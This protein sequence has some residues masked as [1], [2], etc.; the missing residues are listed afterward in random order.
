MP[1]RRRGGFGEL[2]PIERIAR[3]RQHVGQ[4]ADRRERRAADHLDGDT[5]AKLREIELDGLRRA[6]EVR[7]AENRL[8]LVA[9]HVRE[10]RAIAGPQQL[11]RA[12]AERLGSLPHGEH[13]AR[14]V[15]QRRRLPRLRLDVDRRVAVDGIHDRRQIEALRIGAREAAVAVGA[16]LHRRADAV[17]VAQVDVVAHAELVAVVDGRRSRHRQ[18]QAVHELDLRG[19]VLHERREAASNADVDA[20]ARVGGVHLIHVVALFVGDHLERQLVVVAQEDRPLARRRNVGRLPQDLDDRV[21]V[22]L[23]DRHVHARHQRKVIRH[24]A[25]VAVAEI[26][27][28][29]L[30][31]L[32]RL[33]EQHPILVLRV[34]GAPEA[35]HDGV[36]LGQILVHRAVAHAEVRNRVEPQAVDAEIEPM[37]HDANDGVHDGRVVVIQVRLVREEAV[38]I[39]L[40]RDGIPRPVRLLGVREDDA[41]LGETLVGIAP[42][43]ELAVRRAARRRARCLKPR[44]LVGRVVDDELRDDLEAALVRGTHEGLKV[45][46]RAV[47]GIDAEVIGDVVAVVAHR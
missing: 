12:A 17:A 15:E 46:L 13:A 31:P 43:V 42:D 45:A 29:V 47:G 22:L 30:G 2:E 39:V 38:P 37:L 40:V 23:G 18:Q 8:L 34:D 21:A 20:C 32:V 19:I 4:V 28:H 44:M 16:P 3:Q 9:A 10:D 36:R 11:E 41:C 24:V 33:G 27:A 7:D 1:A 14:P 6:L 25:L 35:F 5:A 26:L